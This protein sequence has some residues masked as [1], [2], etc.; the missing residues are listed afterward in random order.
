MPIYVK[1][2]GVPGDVLAEGYTDGWFQADDF[3]FGIERE[4]RE[5]GR[6]GGTEDINIGVGE[7]QECT[8]SK[9]MDSASTTL[10]QLATNGN[11]TAGA[12]IDFVTDFG[13]ERLVYMRYKLDRCFVKSWSISASE[14]ETPTEDVALFYNR[15]AFTVAGAAHVYGWDKVKNIAWTGH[16]LTPLPS[17]GR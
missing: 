5:S 13:E 16:G 9:S 8:I 11:S 6:K 3:H 1:I 7:L 17:P 4:L 2:P 10:A 14:D 12:T 15:I